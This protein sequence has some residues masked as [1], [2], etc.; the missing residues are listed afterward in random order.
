MDAFGPRL[1]YFCRQQGIKLQDLAEQ[2][3]VSRNTLT[4]WK[5]KGRPPNQAVT[6][7]LAK[8]LNLD[9]EETNTLLTSAGY[10]P[11]Y[12][13]KEAVTPSSRMRIQGSAVARAE[14]FADAGIRGIIER[15]RE[16]STLERA[17]VGSKYLPELYFPRSH[18]EANFNRFLTSDSSCFLVV[19]K[20]GRG[21]TNLLC[22]L[23]EALQD[24][25]PVLFVSGRIETKDDYGILTH[26]ASRLGYGENWLACFHDLGLLAAGGVVPLILIDG[27]NESAAPPGTMQAAL[28][29][30]LFQASRCHI[31][32]CVTCRTDFWRFYRAPFWG[33]YT[34]QDF[35]SPHAGKAVRGEDLPLFPQED[36]GQITRRYFDYFHIRGKLIGEA[37]ER[38]RH[39]LLL[40]FLCEA[41]KGEPAHDRDVGEIAQIRLY[42]LF[43]KF[44][45]RKVGNIQDIAGLA[46]PYPIHTLVLDIAGLMYQRH[47]TKVPKEA[48]VKEVRDDL[49]LPDSLYFR[50]LDEEIIL[51][52]ELDELRGTANVIFVYDKFAEYAIALSLFSDRE[53]LFKS[54]ADIVA[55]AILLMKEEARQR[56]PTLR[57][58]L[59]FMVLRVEDRLQAKE[60]HFTII[61]AMLNQDW[62]WRRIGTTLA[63]QLS[64]TEGKAYWGFVG[65]LAQDTRDFVRRIC[66]EQL[67]QVADR[68]IDDM[69]P[70]LLQS[71]QDENASVRQTAKASLLG[72]KATPA[73]QAA[74]FL[75]SAQSFP[76]S[77]ASLAAELL[78]WPMDSHSPLL[79]EKARWLVKENGNFDIQ[80]AIFT[81][82][83][84]LNLP[85][86]KDLY[87]LEELERV[88]QFESGD[89]DTLAN[90]YIEEIRRHVE[91][92]RTTLRVDE[93]RLDSL[94]TIVHQLVSCVRQVVRVS[95]HE[96]EEVLHAELHALLP[97]E[98][99]QRAFQHTLEQI[100]ERPLHHIISQG[101]QDAESTVNW[102]M[103]NQSLRIVDL[104]FEIALSMPAF[105]AGAQ[106]DCLVNPIPSSYSSLIRLCQIADDVLE[107]AATIAKEP[108]STIRL[109]TVLESQSLHLQP[110][111]CLAFRNDF[112][113]KFGVEMSALE[114]RALST[115]GRLSLWLWQAEIEKRRQEQAVDLKIREM[116]GLI[117]DELHSRLSAY[118]VLP[119][120]QEGQHALSLELQALCKLYAQS[121]PMRVV[122][123]LTPLIV[124]T[125]GNDSQVLNQV[126]QTLYWE[127][128]ESFWLISETLLEY[129]DQLVVDFASQVLE[130]AEYT[131]EQNT[132]SSVF[133]SLRTITVNQLGIDPFEVTPGG[134]FAEDL[135][136]G[137]LDFVDLM[138]SLD[139]M[140]PEA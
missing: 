138:V 103:M 89:A 36:F 118:E 34:W 85:A 124:W 54:A 130:Q 111:E 84:Q 115:L 13:V 20:A 15:C 47:Q 131:E 110:E 26:I 92:R 29:E 18:L 65:A 86:Y 55:D 79:R 53:W 68:Y 100:F 28:R 80:R 46:K 117:V 94:R 71:L 42:P 83:A 82:L 106:A 25:R 33:R 76:F 135:N 62:K 133:D 64:H 137:S 114:H 119:L 129:E 132:S 81:H 16:A 7:K 102:S 57:G 139:E 74:L 77:R 126:F 99:Q 50:I 1:D 24:Q 60:I 41:Y 73:C 108:L 48:I 22:H 116:D 125:Q 3:G 93:Q 112:A 8:I 122:E 6:V 9:E 43:S 39:P 120:S 105:A 23:T 45:E 70:L 101:L 40:R 27:I 30:L 109:D 11:K 136:T 123:A 2:I 69:L 17:I 128:R 67:G 104:V 134:F 61:R 95:P 37:W 113:S 21:K 78:L 58:A 127:D 97:D 87:V 90:A 12:G 38:C 63:F 4:N 75:V 5:A 31:K 66:A 32:V 107:E 59:E 35:P 14:K 51:E 49:M 98:Q 19:A 56:F 121:I 88:F 96:Q 72:L 52:E 140:E 91:A 10:A 44:W